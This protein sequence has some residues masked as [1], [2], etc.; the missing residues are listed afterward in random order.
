MLLYFLW[1][2]TREGK[3]FWRHVGRVSLLGGDENH[4]EGGKNEKEHKLPFN[5]E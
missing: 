1:C 2:N 3:Q 5:G 4:E